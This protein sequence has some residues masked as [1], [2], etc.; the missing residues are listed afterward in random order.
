MKRALVLLAAVLLVIDAGRLAAQQRKLAQ[1]RDWA[2]FVDLEAL[3]LTD[4][5]AGAVE[6]LPKA[7][8]EKDLERLAEFLKHKKVEVRRRAALTLGKLGDK[9]GV[10]VMMADFPKATGNDRDNVVVALRILRDPRAIPLLRETLKDP[11]P[12]VR[13][14]AVAA[15]GELKAAEA[16][17]EIV[18][19]TTDKGTTQGCLPMAPGHLAC[20]ALGALGDKKAV[21][22]LI[23]RLSDKDFQSQAQQA[24]EQLTGAKLG[25]HPEHWTAWWKTQQ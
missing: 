13:C 12:Y 4:A 5:Y 20:Y 14:I 22:V 9:R 25:N 23:E 17:D 7:E 24:L 8:K 2:A 3:V 6:A 10:P 18:A 11:S 21:P 16:Y 19:L 15:L 1:P